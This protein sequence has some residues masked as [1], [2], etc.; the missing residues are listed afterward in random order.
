MKKLIIAAAVITTA[1]AT[2]FGYKVYSEANFIATTEREPF[3]SMV[4]DRTVL[5][6][7]YDQMFRDVLSGRLNIDDKTE[8]QMDELLMQ[9]YNTLV[10]A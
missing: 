6:E 9:R 3:T 8:A 7:A 1:I 4:L 2:V 10:S 5:R